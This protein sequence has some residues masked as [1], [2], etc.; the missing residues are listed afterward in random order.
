MTRI[1][2]GMMLALL[3]VSAFMLAFNVELVHAQGETVYINSD[4][5]VSP[6][7][8]PISTTNNISYTFT[9]NIFNES[10]VLERNNI[11]LDGLGYTLRGS[12]SEKLGIDLSGVTNVT[13]K[14]TQITN[15]ATGVQLESASNNV[16]SENNITGNTGYGIYLDS[17]NLNIISKNNVTSNASGISLGDSSNNTVS[18]NS[19]TGNSEGIFLE[20]SDN[21]ISANDVALN[22]WGIY[23]GLDADYNTISENNIAN[24]SAG[25]W[26]STSLKVPPLSSGASGNM[27]YHNNFM[28]SP[29]QVTGIQF[30]SPN[31]W[32]NGYPSGGN[33]WSDYNG[34]DSYSGPYQNV[35]G[36]DGIG[37]TPYVIAANN[38]DH[39][40]LTIP[41]GSNLSLAY[42]AARFTYAP[43]H[44]VTNR[45]VVFNASTTTCINGT[46]IGYDW[47]FGDG[48]NG[49]GQTVSHVYSAVGNYN[50]TLTVISNTRIQD[51]ENQA[52]S[53]QQPPRPTWEFWTLVIASIAAIVVATITIY[54]AA[55]RYE[56]KKNIEERSHLDK[57]LATKAYVSTKSLHTKPKLY[58]LPQSN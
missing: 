7:S 8:A 29:S 20:S 43:L 15:F 2:S 1:V 44:P 38:T 5:S 50:V 13:V 45:T 12:G 23:F 52:I 35:T 40:P 54:L 57:Y 33:Y 36:S 26:F 46:I 14:N 30:S 27:I 51:T 31:T 41:F 58:E 49:V 16:I 32:D 10:I 21:T 47:D 37:D 17:S 39:Y 11:V 25:M 53:V 55:K 24:N 22:N 4:G 3:L 34:L 56:R 42:P 18:F 9:G 19:V 6:P 48:E 28:N